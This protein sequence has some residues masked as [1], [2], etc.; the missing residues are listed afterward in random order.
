MDKIDKRQN[1]GNHAYSALGYR[2]QQ[3]F[4]SQASQSV[5]GRRSRRD[6]EHTNED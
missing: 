3:V 5:H 1:M 2:D 6:R 4:D